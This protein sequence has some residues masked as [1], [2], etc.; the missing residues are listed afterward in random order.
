MSSIY[1][2]I[3][4]ETEK[5]LMKEAEPV[6]LKG[7]TIR[8]LPEYIQLVDKLAEQLG[9]SRQTFLSS[10]IYDAVE[11]ALNAYASVFDEPS[12]VYTETKESCGFV[13]GDL[14]KTQ[15][16]DFCSLNNLDPSD[17]SSMDEFKMVSDLAKDEGFIK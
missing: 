1:E 13:Y 14:T 16:F 6:N 4:N 5:A 3:K 17:S 2:R 8:L 7:C 9:E 12:K 15:F 11:E 10:L